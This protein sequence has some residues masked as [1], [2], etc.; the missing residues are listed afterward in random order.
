MQI[1]S[2]GCRVAL[3]K[4]SAKSDC[5]PGDSVGSFSDMLVDT[6]RSGGLNRIF[7]EACGRALVAARQRSPIVGASGSALSV[8]GLQQSV[9]CARCV[10]QSELYPEAVRLKRS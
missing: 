3:C 10:R 7:C 9:L 2:F 6:V 8:V 5:E 4:A 1:R